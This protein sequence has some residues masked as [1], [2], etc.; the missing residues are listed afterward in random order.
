MLPIQKLEAL[1]G[2]FKGKLEG[3]RWFFNNDWI[4]FDPFNDANAARAVL[5]VVPA[6]RR[7]EVMGRLEEIVLGSLSAPWTREDAYYMMVA[8]PKHLA[9]AI[10]DTLCSPQTNDA[11]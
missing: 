7:N 10:L 1:K 5:E 6:E 4:V 11:P 8:K 2:I 3:E 9:Q